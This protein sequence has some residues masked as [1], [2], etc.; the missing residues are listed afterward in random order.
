MTCNIALDE[1][2]I[3]RERRSP[4]DNGGARPAPP[5]SRAT[6]VPYQKDTHGTQRTTTVTPT[7]PM[8]WSL[9]ALAA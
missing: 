2:D 7:P 6:H 8:T 3:T 4:A 1:P 9:S 5:A